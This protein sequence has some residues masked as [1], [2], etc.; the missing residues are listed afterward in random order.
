MNLLFVFGI[1][2]DNDIIWSDVITWGENQLLQ[3]EIKEYIKDNKKLK[4]DNEFSSFLYN[5]INSDWKRKEFK[6]FEYI[7][8]EPPFW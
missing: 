7:S 5:K 4:I 1:N 3:I 8:I 2:D 6:D